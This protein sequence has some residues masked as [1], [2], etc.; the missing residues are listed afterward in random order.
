MV[1]YKR[2][3]LYITIIILLAGL[4]LGVARCYANR[5]IVEDAISPTDKPKLTAAYISPKKDSIPSP[6]EYDVMLYAFGEFNDTNDGLI[7][8]RPEKLRSLVALKDSNPDLKII[9]SVAGPKFEGF[10]E[11]ARS[12]KKRKKFAASCRAIV[13]TL[14][15]DGIDLDWEFPGTT[16]GGH[17]A[18]PSDAKNYIL[19]MKQL[20]KS[21]GDNK[22]LS[23]YSSN[24]GLFIDLKGMMPYVDYVMLSG[25]DL[26]VPKDGKIRAHNSNLYKSKKYASWSI[27]QS[28]AR[29]LKSGVPREKILLGIPF[30]TYGASPKPRT[31]WNYIVPKFYNNDTPQWDEE[32]CV[33]YY[34]DEEG[35]LT[36]VLDNEKSIQIKC[37]YI[38]DKGLAGGFV[39]NY[40]GDYPDRRLGKALKQGLKNHE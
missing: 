8:P 13:D 18:S 2:F 16:A 37:K 27:D 26:S 10:S 35:N 28:L 1:N 4:T 3:S 5:S 39:W 22:W 17:S 24:S 21:L 20:R 36:G 6:W 30:Y 15:I 23:F 29:H 14:G 31:M 38:H 11:M 34:A 32:A 19:V 7:I 33:P 9:L 40:D 12:P 25:Y